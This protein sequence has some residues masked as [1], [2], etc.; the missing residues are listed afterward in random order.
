MDEYYF[1]KYLPAIFKAL[2][3]NQNPHGSHS[4][5]DLL[6]NLLTF[7]AHLQRKTVYFFA[8][9]VLLLLTLGL[10]VT[11]FFQNYVTE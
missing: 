2:K 11:I 6:F 5:Q 4:Y 3:K 9:V 10:C 7:S 1:L 8:Y